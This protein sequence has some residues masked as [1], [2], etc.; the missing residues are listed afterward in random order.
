MPKTYISRDKKRG[1]IYYSA[2]K[3]TAPNLETEKY[4]EVPEKYFWKI[5]A[6]EVKAMRKKDD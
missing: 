2:P 6:N 3:L 1:G 5:L 4:T